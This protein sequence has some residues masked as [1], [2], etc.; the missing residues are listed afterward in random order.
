MSQIAIIS[1]VMHDDLYEH[2][3]FFYNSLPYKKIVV[4]GKDGMYNFEFLNHVIINS[5]KY[6]FDYSIFVD[7]DCFITNLEAF[8]NLINYVIKNDI[9]CIGMPDGGVVPTRIHNPVSI[10][11]FFCIMNL[12]KIRKSYNE[13]N[14]PGEHLLDD[15]KQY[16][17]HHLMKCLYHY[18]QMEPYYRLFFWMLRNGFKIEY[19]DAHNFKDDGVT[20]ILKNHE[21]IDFAYHTWEARKWNTIQYDR[22]N[23]VIEYCKKL[24]K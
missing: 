23:K 2:S 22:I 10:N 1:N 6:P 18:D 11:P 20:T 19:L 12:K 14:L 21:G 15:L 5:E 8:K 17:P 16:T 7:E 9:D 13:D 24:N 4:S 3:K